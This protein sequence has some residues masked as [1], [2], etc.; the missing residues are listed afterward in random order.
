MVF[1]T[2]KL[3]GLGQLTTERGLDRAPIVFDPLTHRSGVTTRLSECA[4]GRVLDIISGIEP[5]PACDNVGACTR[6]TREP[7]A[8]AIIDLGGG[9]TMDCAK[10]T[11]AAAATDCIG[12][13]LLRGRPVTDALSPIAV[14]TTAGISSEVD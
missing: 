8:R 6:W 12:L 13:E 2:G 5:S 14:S 3:D 1:D 4:G 7:G 11:V 9:S 10:A